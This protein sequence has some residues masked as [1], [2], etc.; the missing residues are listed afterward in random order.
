MATIYNQEYELSVSDSCLC[1]LSPN[2]SVLEFGSATGN[3]TRYMVEKYNC[4]VTCIEKIAEMAEKGRPFAKKMIVA[5]IETDQWEAE[6]DGKFD[7]IMFA[8]VLEHLHDPK[9]TLFRAIPFLKKDGFILTSIPNIGHNAILLS[10]R[11]GDFTYRP[12][13]LLDDT[14]IYF[15]TRKTILSMF[16]ECGLFLAAEEN[17]FISPCNTEFDTYYFKNP[18][19]ALSLVNKDDGHVYRFVHKWSLNQ[20]EEININSNRKLPI[21]RRIFDLIYDPLKYIAKKNNLKLPSFIQ[22][23]I[24]NP[25]EK[26]SE[27]RYGKYSSKG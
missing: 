22:K 13:G 24:F 11:N 25:L 4:E 27:K 14:H 12:T 9:K 21:L 18:L 1:F 26:E 2:A 7:I 17:K 8:D 20:I 10:L 5:D 6:L 23:I 3:N 16:Y 19:L 15:F